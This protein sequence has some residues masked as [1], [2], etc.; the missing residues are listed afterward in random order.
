MSLRKYISFNKTSKC[1]LNT[2]YPCNFSFN[3]T[4]Y[5]SSLQFYVKRKQEILDRFNHDLSNKILSTNQSDKLLFYSHTIDQYNNKDEFTIPLRYR[6]M[7]SANTLKFIQNRSLA[8]SLLDTK[9]DIILYDADDK[10]WGINNNELSDDALTEIRLGQ[11]LLGYSL[12]EVRDL[13]KTL[14]QNYIN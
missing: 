11:N 8:D 7:T 6:I 3:N 9:N 4:Y 5:N 13:L 1:F 10:I 12:M 14:N 2:S